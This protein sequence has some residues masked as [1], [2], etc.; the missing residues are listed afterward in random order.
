MFTQNGFLGQQDV[1]HLNDRSTPYGT[2][3]DCSSFSGHTATDKSSI[4]EHF[5]TQPVPSAKNRLKIKPEARYFN[6]HRIHEGS[7]FLPG[8]VNCYLSHKCRRNVKKQISLFKS[9]EFQAIFLPL[10]SLFKHNL[11]TNYF[12]WSGCC[13]KTG[14]LFLF[15]RVINGSTDSMFSVLQTTD[16]LVDFR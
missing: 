5:N 4:H 2:C 9:W 6:K 3:F 12:P 1:T 7:Y 16:Y 13:I 11:N 8:P 15:R 10:S 14:A